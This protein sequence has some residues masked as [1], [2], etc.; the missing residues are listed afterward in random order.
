M[1]HFHGLTSLFESKTFFVHF[2]Q[3]LEMVYFQF[4]SHRKM[5]ADLKNGPRI[6]SILT[7]FGHLKRLKCT[8]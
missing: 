1:H 8:L 5:E 4:C 7:I 2:Q 3:D 6:F